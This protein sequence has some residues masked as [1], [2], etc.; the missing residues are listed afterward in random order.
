MPSARTPRKLCRACVHAE[1][2]RGPSGNIVQRTP[3]RCKVVTG[4]RTTQALVGI[5][6]LVQTLTP[7]VIWPNDRAHAC[8][9]FDRLPAEPV[10]AP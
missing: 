3:G 9:G 10:V 1:W 2:R 8:P 7:R 4:L 6:C 5:P